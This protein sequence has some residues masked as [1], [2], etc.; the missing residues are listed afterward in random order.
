M[1]CRQCEW[2]Q[3]GTAC[4]QQ[5]TCGKTPETA[6]AADRLLYVL[7]GLA[8]TA[9]NGR[10]KGKSVSEA[11]R[12]IMR[13]LYATMTNVDFDPA[14]LAAL[15]EEAVAA[16]ESI[17]VP[18]EAPPAAR[19]NP[20]GG[21]A[22]DEGPRPEGVSAEGEDPLAASLRE[23]AILG[24][25]GM[26][27]YLS[28]AEALGKHDD[29]FSRFAEELL[30][31]TLEP[32]PTVED[33]LALTLRTGE[34][35]L[36]VM[37]MLDKGHADLFG[38]PV[39]SP[40][41]LGHAAGP[42]VALS[43]HDLKELSVLLDQA[44]ERGVNVY[45]HCEALPAH[46]YPG[47]RRPALAGHWGTGWQNQA[48][49]LSEFPGPA[50]F[51]SNCIQK[52]RDPENAFTVGPVAW[53]GCVRLGRLHDGHTDYGPVLDRALAMGGFAA[54]LKGPAVQTGFNWRNVLAQADGILGL[55]KRGRIRRFILIGGCDGARAS[56]SYFRR[57]AELAPAEA[58]IL[59]LGCGKFRI[60]DLPLDDIE[61]VP[62][63]IDLGQCNDAFSAVKIA[64]ALAEALNTPLDMLPLS[65]AVSWHEQKAV[66]V[67]LSL[68]NL[69]VKNIR[70]G[71][72]L[73]AFVHPDL[74]AVLSQR[75]GL[76]P[77]ASPEDDI[78]AMMAGS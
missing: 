64:S 8:W 37:E 17:G 31:R 24:L 18:S 58:V 33:W 54:D 1:F 5:G 21:T 49:D 38:V 32:T 72:T 62:R 34:K 52:P 14:S 74:M 6:E 43:G 63:L 11:D 25:K 44:S 19:Y 45:T 28:H 22:N 76:K 42:A 23:T 41:P 4:T 26:A 53:P 66:S 50:V 65:L 10:K 20:P 59:T 40:V 30:I 13:G 70:L 71:P 36:G 61:G 3:N 16:R 78:R 67:L 15:T 73:P 9:A 69:G 57:L 39:P 7:K 29:L 2:T 55:I 75:Y 12:L 27:A 48:R 77:T 47:L 35:S 51:T 60:F 46:G 56:R 68:L